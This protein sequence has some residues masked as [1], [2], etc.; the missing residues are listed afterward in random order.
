MRDEG[1]AA[2]DAA[3]AAGNTLYSTGHS[4]RNG[5][6]AERYVSTGTCI[7]CS[8]A[9]AKRHADRDP[10]A[11]KARSAAQYEKHRARHQMRWAARYDANKQK[12]SERKRKYYEENREACA[13]R[14][15]RYREAN[16]E[17]ESERRKQYRAANADRIRARNAAYREANRDRYASYQKA[18]EC[19]IRKAMPPW[20][21]EAE[22]A[23]FYA[24]ARDFTIQTS[25]AHHVDHIVPLQGRGVCGLHVPWNLQVL[26]A[27]A[28]QSKG[29][30]LAA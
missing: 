17:T 27:Q 18:R 5:H 21:T 14:G 10:A 1:R 2:R 24:L 12:E 7:A 28:N 23:P 22:L 4:C 29:N 13:A 30:R 6:L 11:A 8:A 3:R 25:I 20:V 9:R 16:R 26:P 15:K 19:R